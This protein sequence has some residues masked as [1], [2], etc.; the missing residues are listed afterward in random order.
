MRSTHEGVAGA[1]TGACPTKI[2]QKPAVWLLES[3]TNLIYNNTTLNANHDS[4]RILH[5]TFPCMQRYWN[6]Q[7]HQIMN[8]QL[9]YLKGVYVKILLSHAH[10]YICNSTRVAKTHRIC[11]RIIKPQMRPPIGLFLCIKFQTLEVLKSMYII[12]FIPETTQAEKARMER[13]PR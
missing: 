5:L 1:R 3:I 12:K 11:S 6:Y 4:K 8:Q 13:I 9:S 10:K 7:R 2:Y